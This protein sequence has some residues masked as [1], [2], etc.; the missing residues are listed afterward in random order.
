MP[1]LKKLPDSHPMDISQHSAHPHETECLSVTVN[2]IAFSRISYVFYINV[3][4]FQNYIKCII[5]HRRYALDSF[6]IIV[7]RLIHV[8][9][10]WAHSFAA[11]LLSTNSIPLHEYTSIHSFIH[12]LIHTQIVYK[13]LALTSIPAI[14]VICMHKYLCMFP[15]CGITGS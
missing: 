3:Y 4:K 11:P 13:T 7:M 8:V 14:H 6:S 2:W 15:N 12:V 10:S 5:I 9:H 1:T